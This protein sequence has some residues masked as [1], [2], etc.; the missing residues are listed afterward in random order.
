MI[1]YRALTAFAGFLANP[2]LWF[3]GRRFRERMAKDL[4]GLPQGAI[5]IHAASVGEI[6]SAR[7]IMDRL[8]REYPVLVTTN[9]LTGRDLVREWGYASC[10]APLDLPQA[11]R[12]FINHTRPCLAVTVEAEIWPN[13]SRILARRGIAQAM[14]G[15]RISAGSARNWSRLPALIRPAL[16]NLNLLSAQDKESEARFLALGLP[17]DRVVA[18]MNLKLIGPA[19]RP[20]T[21]LQKKYPKTLLIAS[22]HEDEESI[23]LAGVKHL[24]ASHPDL[25][26]IWAPRHPERFEPLAKA[27]PDFARRSAGANATEP[28]LLADTMGEMDLWYQAAGTVLL[29]GSFGAAAGHSP[30]EAASHGSA[31]IHGPSIGSA[32]SDYAALDAAGAAVAATAADWHIMAMRICENPALRDDMTRKARAVLNSLAGNPEQ[33]YR[34]LSALAQKSRDTDISRMSEG[35]T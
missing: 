16:A 15:A 7:F 4:H 3:A 29:A 33:L 21:E 11:V 10:L 26:I 30:W 8:A 31:I 14:I 23:I 19:Q 28:Y 34:H 18:P 12:R 13:R 27:L 25:R 9:S 6:A 17:A 5:W 24:R 35:N 22:S 1:T 32:E 2:L 20:D